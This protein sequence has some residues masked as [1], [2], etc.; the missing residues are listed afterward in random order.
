MTDTNHYPRSYTMTDLSRPRRAMSALDTLRVTLNSV[1][2]H[3]G[4]QQHRA[5]L[6]R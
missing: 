3:A 1:P 5:G 4:A 6:H 2:R